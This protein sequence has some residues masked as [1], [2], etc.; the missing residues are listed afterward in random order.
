MTV[1]QSPSGL[2]SRS[3]IY[4]SLFLLNV[5][6]E[7]TGVI[8]WVG[9]EAHSTIFPVIQDEKWKTAVIT[10]VKLWEKDV[11]QPEQDKNETG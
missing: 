11:K 7:G 8:Y 1:L 9:Y 3:A 4:W 5:S 2:L 10:T 6:A